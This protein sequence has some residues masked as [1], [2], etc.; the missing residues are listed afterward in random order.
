MNEEAPI[1]PKIKYVLKQISHEKLE[2][3]MLEILS[4]SFFDFE[5][6]WNNQH[7]PNA[8]NLKIYLTPDIYSK[9]Y[10][11]KKDIEEIIKKRINDSFELLVPD[12]KLLPNLEKLEIIASEVKPIYTKWEEINL[13]Q[14]KL[15]E[16]LERSNGSID[17]QSIGNTAR[18][19]MDKL[20]RAVFNSELHKPNDPS[21]ELS[22]GKYKNQLNTF[23]STELSGKK[24]KELRKLGESS[25]EFVG[26][27]IDLMNSTTHK[28]NAKRHYAELCVISAISAVSII[29]TIHELEQ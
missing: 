28:L 9:Y 12:L 17:Y 15:I 18:T 11:M 24:N 20:A 26:S 23:I 6:H 16:I 13:I 8:H 3:Y 1:V 2:K 22:N 25:I 29:K 4:H 7:F 5:K 14:Q 27:S 19:L 21:M 10:G